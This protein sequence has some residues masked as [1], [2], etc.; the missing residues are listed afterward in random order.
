MESPD[1]ASGRRYGTHFDESMPRTIFSTA[2]LQNPRRL[3][4][5]FLW[6]LREFYA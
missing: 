3:C 1:E 6:Q 5:E 4:S 2:N